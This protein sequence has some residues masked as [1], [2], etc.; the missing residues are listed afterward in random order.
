[1][2][3]LLRTTDAHPIPVTTAVERPWGSYSFA[4]ISA[5]LTQ[6]ERQFVMLASAAITFLILTQKIVIGANIEIGVLA[7]WPFTVWAFLRGY[8]TISTPRLLGYL[9]ASAAIIGVSTANASGEHFSTSSMLFLVGLHF[10]FFFVANVRRVVY[11]GILKNFQWVCLFIAGM[12]YFQWAQQ[13]AGFT[14]LDMGHYI[15]DK[16][17]FLHYNYIQKIS[18]F[19]RWYKPNAFFMLET[20]HTSQLLAIGVIIEVVMFRRWWLMI[21]LLLAIIMTFGGTGTVMLIATLP[22]LIPYLS[23]RIIIAGAA[24]TPI[25]LLLAAKLGYL[26]NALGRTQ[27]F[28]TQGTSGQGRFIAPFQIL[29]DTLVGI[30]R[31]AFWGIGAGTVSPYQHH[32]TDM[33]NPI[34]KSVV[35]YGVP[36]GLTW[37]IWFHACVFSSRVPFAIMWVVLFQFDWTGGGMLV[38]IQ[39]YYCLFICAM[40]V[41]AKPTTQPISN[42]TRWQITARRSATT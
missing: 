25:L 39:T 18:Y 28:N 31:S 14:M 13:A 23:R 10:P 29:H 5:A 42:N 17:M 30:P 24:A 15:P 3:S 19:S 35:E 4:D 16:Y 40:I 32:I 6:Q 38:P 36:A 12:V 21:W 7:V 33:M 11:L 22:F 8:S 20:S 41:P 26:S 37:F 1:M 34:A 27:E 9:L 2:A